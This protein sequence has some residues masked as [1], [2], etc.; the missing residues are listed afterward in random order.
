MLVD[1]LSD[2]EL[3]LFITGDAGRQT[4]AP[5]ASFFGLPPLCSDLAPYWC[6]RFELER[7]KPETAREGFAWEI[8]SGDND[9]VIARKF[10][11]SG[12][13]AAARRYHPDRV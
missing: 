2:E 3:K 10:V 9:R 1:Q 5:E 8:S 12:F 6:A 7:R 13:R 4:K 11:E